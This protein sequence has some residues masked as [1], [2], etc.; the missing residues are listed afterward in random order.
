MRILSAIMSLMIVALLLAAGCSDS[1][2]SAPSTGAST[3]DGAT[4]PPTGKTCTETYTGQVPYNDTEFYYE[5]EGV[6]RKFCQAEPYTDFTHKIDSLGKICNIY[7]T[8]NGNITGDWIIKAK[9]ITTSAGGGPESEPITKTIA[10]GKTELFSFQ[11]DQADTPTS[12]I[13]KNVE[14]PTIEKCKYSFYSDVK[15]SRTVVKYREGELTR[16]VPC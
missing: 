11:Y 13:N 14:I 8:N 6:G 1:Q 3:G 10:T 9:F 4:A 5:K 2:P 7:I 16:Q 12:C 15:K